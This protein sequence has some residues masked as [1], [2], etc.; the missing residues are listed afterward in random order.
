MSEWSD[1]LRDCLTASSAL[2]GA[3]AT[4]FYREPTRKAVTRM[5]EEL[6]DLSDF[7]TAWDEPEVWEKAEKLEEAL[8]HL[9]LKEGARDYA[10]L[11][12][13]GQEGSLC[14][15]ESSYLEHTLYGATTR[16]IKKIYKKGGFEKE[17]AFKEPDDHVAVEFAFRFLSGLDLSERMGHYEREFAPVVKELKEERAFVRDHLAIWIPLLAAHIEKTAETP[18]FK[19]ASSLAEALVR[20]DL[21][22]HE[23]IL[24][25]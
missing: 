10:A 18:F 7:K 22:L 19:A 3:L 24:S 2:Y 23:A 4:S 20:A 16:E 6:I 14:P 8:V 25:S 21:K 12:A 15:S 1:S 5:R 13:G 9:K 17:K 11:F